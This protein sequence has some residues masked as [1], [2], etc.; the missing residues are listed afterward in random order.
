[1]KNKHKHLLIKLAIYNN[2]VVYFDDGLPYPN[3]D[4]IE[5]R[6]V[7]ILD[8]CYFLKN[9]S[10]TDNGTVIMYLSQIYNIKNY[11]FYN[12]KDIKKI[13]R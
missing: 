12:N 9:T 4:E 10:N 3:K 7:E 8:F 1:M 5:R 11:L 6:C 2:F 13:L